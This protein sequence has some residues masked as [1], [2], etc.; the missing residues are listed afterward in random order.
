MGFAVA[1]PLFEM[2]VPHSSLS[3]GKFPH[4]AEKRFAEVNENKNK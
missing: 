2:K 1:V 4:I 3:G